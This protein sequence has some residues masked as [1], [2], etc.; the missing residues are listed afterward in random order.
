MNELD[1]RNLVKELEVAD[2]DYLPKLKILY[3]LMGSPGI[4]IIIPADMV[5]WCREVGLNPNFNSEDRT[6]W[7]TCNYLN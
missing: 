6:T 4:G 3:L 1:L 5:D 2:K 7:W